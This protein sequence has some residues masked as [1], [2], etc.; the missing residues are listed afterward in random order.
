[1]PL[2]ETLPDH[3]FTLAVLPYQKLPPHFS[4]LFFV[5]GMLEPRPLARGTHSVSLRGRR[6]AGDAVNCLFE[7]LVSGGFSRLGGIN[8]PLNEIPENSQDPA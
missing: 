8:K 2:S 4:A 3:L 7:P 6:K 1:M 5:A